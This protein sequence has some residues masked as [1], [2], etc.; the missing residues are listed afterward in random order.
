[1]PEV[2]GTFV[3]L[4]ADATDEEIEAFCRELGWTP[5]MGDA[6]EDVGAEHSEVHD[7]STHCSPPTMYSAHRG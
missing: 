1:V 5:E 3:L 7:Q 6:D 4:D 2:R